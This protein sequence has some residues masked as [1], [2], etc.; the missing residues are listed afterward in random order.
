MAD[1]YAARISCRYLL[2]NLSISLNKALL[3]LIL[4]HNYFM[5]R[6]SDNQALEAKNLLYGPRR[7]G[8]GPALVEEGNGF[9][10]FFDELAEGRLRLPY[11][12][13]LPPRII[14]REPTQG[15]DGL[16]PYSLTQIDNIWNE[17]VGFFARKGKRENWLLIDYSAFDP[18]PDCE[19]PAPG[20]HKEMAFLKRLAEA[21]DSDVSIHFSFEHEGQLESFISAYGPSPFKVAN[22]LDDGPEPSQNEVIKEVARRG[23]LDDEEIAALDKCASLTQAWADPLARDA[24]SNLAEHGELSLARPLR[25][26]ANLSI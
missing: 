3:V 10:L 15:E 20:T 6:G 2:I 14:T 23:V 9:D 19:A 1:D 12:R 5:G 13:L 16:G 4:L 22:V 11:H 21:V 18:D 8:S 7:R 24:L 25:D 26:F 17:P